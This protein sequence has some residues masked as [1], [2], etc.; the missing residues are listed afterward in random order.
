L[1]RLSLRYLPSDKYEAAGFMLPRYCP[2]CGGHIAG[3]SAALTVDGDVVEVDV[4]IFKDFDD[5]ESLFSS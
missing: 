5:V 2:F 3:R 4:D 1:V